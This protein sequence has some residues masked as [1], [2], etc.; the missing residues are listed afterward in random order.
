MKYS[1]VFKIY[2]DRL[3]DGKVEKIDEEVSSEFLEVCEKSLKFSEKVKV[4]GQVY[5][6][7]DYLVLKFS[8]DLKAF[9]PCSICNEQVSI[10]ISR[11][12]MYNSEP[13]SEV[14]GGVFDYGPLLRELIL[15]EVPQFI[16]CAGSD[17]RCPCRKEIEKFLK[18]PAV[19]KDVEESYHPFADLRVND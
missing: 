17:G 12:D 2:V 9:L 11:G 6:A 14:S 15:L 1:D 10:A 16:E 4:G 8:F 7:D 13:L 3:D 18:K 5:L 19:S